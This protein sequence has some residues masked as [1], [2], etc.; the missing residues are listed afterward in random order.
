MSIRISVESISKI[1]EK[2]MQA[3]AHE[4]SLRCEKAKATIYPVRDE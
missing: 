4:D 3:D 1:G 2:V